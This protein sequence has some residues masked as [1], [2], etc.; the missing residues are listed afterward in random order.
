MNRYAPPSEDALYRP[1][2]FHG[3]WAGRV[4]EQAEPITGRKALKEFL[5][6]SLHQSAEQ[7]DALVQRLDEER[8]VEISDLALLGRYCRVGLEVRSAS[9]PPVGIQR[10]AKPV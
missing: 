9:V 7:A 8:S 4:V 3:E 1:T 5:E 6:V 10:L 2:F